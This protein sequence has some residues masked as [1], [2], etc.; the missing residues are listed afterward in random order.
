MKLPFSTNRLRRAA[1][2][3][4]SKIA[5]LTLFLSVSSVP[6]IYVIA[7]ESVVIA[8]AVFA[9]KTWG[10]RH[11]TSIYSYTYLRKI[12]PLLIGIVL[13]I[14][15]IILSSLSGITE[16][17]LDAVLIPFPIIIIL[18]VIPKTRNRILGML[19]I[20]F[21]KYGTVPQWLDEWAVPPDRPDSNSSSN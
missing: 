17:I 3:V 6:L 20:A 2:F 11:E 13:L 15:I 7:I 9:L 10:N 21:N 19:A 14:S 4:A 1:V 8:I 5:A 16:D 18:L 12:F